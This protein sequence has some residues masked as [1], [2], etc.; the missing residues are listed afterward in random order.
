V[1]SFLLHLKLPGGKDGTLEKPSASRTVL[2][3]KDWNT[4]YAKYNPETIS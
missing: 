2:K 3:A 4:R 1:E